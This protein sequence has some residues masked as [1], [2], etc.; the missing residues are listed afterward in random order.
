MIHL[1]SSDIFLAIT[2]LC[3]SQLQ[4]LRLEPLYFNG[5]MR[6]VNL[7]RKCI[8]KGLKLNGT[9]LLQ[10]T[11]LCLTFHITKTVEEDRLLFVFVCLFV[12]LFCSVLPYFLIP[13]LL[14]PYTVDLLLLI[15]E[16]KC[17]SKYQVL[18]NTI[19]IWT[20]FAKG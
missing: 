9:M 6:H 20:H 5:K 10:L 11:Y 17:V 8:F 19:H 1:Y 13:S 15:C 2:N 18:S 16:S 12:C 7:K 4:I 3:W 14:C